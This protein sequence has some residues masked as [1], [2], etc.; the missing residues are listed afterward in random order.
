M[1]RPFQ[2]KRITGY[3][4]G[5]E[6]TGARPGVDAFAAFLANRAQGL[7]RAFERVAG[8]FAEFADSRVQGRFLI[9]EFPLGDGPDTSV[10]ALPEGSA[11]MYEEDF[12]SGG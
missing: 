10:P 1:A 9:F 11:R 7:E 4:A 8:L 6:V 3:R 12:G 2:F 5:I